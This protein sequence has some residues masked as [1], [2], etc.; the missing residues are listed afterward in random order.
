[1][2]VNFVVSV[3]G[4]VTVA[5][6]SGGLGDDGDRA[7]FHGLRES[8][9]AILA[10]T[11]TVRTENY[12]R[13]LGTA[14]RRERRRAAGLPPEPLAVLISRSGQ[15]PDE[16]PLLA[17]PEARVAIVAAQP[18]RGRGWR[19]QVTHLTPEDDSLAAALA[20]VRQ[21]FDVR[22]WLCEGGPALFAA[23]LAEDLVDELFLTVAP[24][25]VGG[26]G[27]G[28]TRGAALPEPAA[29]ELRWL[30]E[31]RGALYARY[32]VKR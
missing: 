4:H 10:G 5:G 25:L 14:E 19:A 3:D 24:K 30:L 13:M 26:D 2:V 12:G 23:L 15:V 1:V 7:M 32:A 9:D 16:I 6:R 11:N 17:E 31:R 21:R 27:P 18:P 22:L 28:P 8:V 20:A 29:L